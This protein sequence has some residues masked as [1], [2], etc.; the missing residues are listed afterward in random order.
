[1]ES[2][3]VRARETPRGPQEHVVLVTQTLQHWSLLEKS[4]E[5]NC[6]IRR[7]D[8]KNCSRAQSYQ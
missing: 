4:F 1:M 6:E 3:P 5:W 2:D 8:H 7:T